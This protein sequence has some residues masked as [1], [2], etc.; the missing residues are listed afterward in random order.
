VP[1][2]MSRLGVGIAESPIFPSGAKLN[3]IW[4]S[5]N[6]RARGATLLDG[7]APLGTALGS[8]LIAGLISELDSWRVSFVISGVGTMIAGAVAYS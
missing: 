3:G 7:G 8:L 5:P 2:L 6:E 4:M 1:L